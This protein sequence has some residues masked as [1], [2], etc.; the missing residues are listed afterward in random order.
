MAE[1]RRIILVEDNQYD[2][3]LIV[4]ALAKCGIANEVEI[5][6]R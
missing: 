2:A 1:L 3:E 6:R 5:V 4:A